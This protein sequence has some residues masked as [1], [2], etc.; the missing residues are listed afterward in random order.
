MSVHDKTSQWATNAA[1]G[2]RSVSDGR[3]AATHENGLPAGYSNA[4][5]FLQDREYE[6][7][8]GAYAR[9]ARS[10]AMAEPRLGALVQKDLAAIAALEKKRHEAHQGPRQAIASD[11]KLETKSTRP[12]PTGKKPP[13]KPGPTPKAKQRRA[14]RNPEL[15]ITDPYDRITTFEYKMSDLF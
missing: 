10:T 12:Q 15:E 13:P 2:G 1:K 5:Q 6:K 8:R 7:A 9:L 4:H 3:A 14:S 11:A